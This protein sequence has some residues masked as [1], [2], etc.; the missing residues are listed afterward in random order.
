MEEKK[1]VRITSNQSKMLENL[2]NV[3]GISENQVFRIALVKLYKDFIKD[4]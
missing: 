4:E 2:K 1:T 3:L